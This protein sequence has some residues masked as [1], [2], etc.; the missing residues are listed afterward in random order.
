MNLKELL[1]ENDMTCA[2]LAR[3]IGM[4][5]SLVSMWVS[6]KACPRLE[7]IPKLAE[8]FSLNMGEIIALFIKEERS[9]GN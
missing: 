4:S 7:V 9:N 5:R 1:K 6:G 3:K 8:I 2:R